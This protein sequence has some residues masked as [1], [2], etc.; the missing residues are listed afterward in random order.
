MISSVSYA[1]FNVL[2]WFVIYVY[3]TIITITNGATA[4]ILLTRFVLERNSR[5][6]YAI[7]A[8]AP[9]EVT[10]AT[11]S[12]SDIYIALI[13]FLSWIILTYTDQVIHP[14]QPIQFDFIYSQTVVVS[15]INFVIIYATF[16]LLWRIK[17]SCE[18]SSLDRG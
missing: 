5:Y 14:L 11:L 12:F 9:S 13:D 18:D 4:G 3:F 17:Y 15:I 8:I 7:Y 10:F 1:Y 16:I 2:G 6:P